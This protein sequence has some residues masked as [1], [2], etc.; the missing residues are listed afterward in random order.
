MKQCIVHL[1]HSGGFYGAERM[2]LDHCLSFPGEHRVIFLDAPSELLARFTESGVAC[3]NCVGWRELGRELRRQ[4]GLLN[5]HNFRAQLAAWLAARW[6]GLPLVFT[7][8]GFTPRTPKQ[9]LYTW[10]SLRLCRSAVVS[11]VVCVAQ[12]IARLHEHAGV[13]CAKV[14]VIPNGLPAGTVEPRH[15]TGSLVGFVG[16]L[17]QEKGPDLFLDA[18]LPLCQQRPDLQLVLLGDGPERASLQS[19]IDTAGLADQI[20]LPGYQRDMAGWLSRLSMLVMSSRTE[21]TPMILLEAMQAAT[22]VVAFAVG[23]I[24]DM[25]QNQHTALLVAV[26]DTQTLQDSVR[27]LLDEPQLATQLASRAQQQQRELYHLPVLAE[28]WRSLYADV[29]SAGVAS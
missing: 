2:L 11:R 14:V 20:S 16:R 28:R 21:G 3:H 17:S 27:R 9:R 8:H 23:G 22:P 29:M 26:E 6:L 4:S 10:I 1:I 15:V 7:Q 24:P 18:L 12:S 5:A 25:L 19:R 13:R